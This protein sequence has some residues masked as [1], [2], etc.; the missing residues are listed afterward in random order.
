MFRLFRLLLFR[1]LFSSFLLV[2]SCG[3]SHGDQHTNQERAEARRHCQCIRCPRAEQQTSV[4]QRKPGRSGLCSSNYSSY[5]KIAKLDSD[6][7]RAR[8]AAAVPSSR[9]AKPPLLHGRRGQC[10]WQWSQA[11]DEA[12]TF[13]CISANSASTRG[14]HPLL[15]PILS[16]RCSAWGCGYRYYSQA[17]NDTGPHG[18]SNATSSSASTGSTTE[19]QNTPEEIFV[20]NTTNQNTSAQNTIAQSTIF[21]GTIFRGTIFQGTIPQG[22]LAGHSWTKDQQARLE[23][24]NTETT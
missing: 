15:G 14:A 5:A 23:V 20:Q 19:T 2:L 16:P 4:T 7:S 17:Y 24:T 18:S 3:A 1:S 10:Q 9:R 8:S 11:E 21:Q 22:T 12:T 13:F 6:S